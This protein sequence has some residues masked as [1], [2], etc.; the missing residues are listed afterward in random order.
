MAPQ[1]NAHAL[2]AD[3]SSDGDSKV[4]TYSLTSLPQYHST[5]NKTA[6]LASLR[7]S[8]GKL[9]DEVNAF[10]TKKMEQEKTTLGGKEKDLRKEEENYGE[11]DVDA[12]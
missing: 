6:Y 7:A 12:A 10:L 11:E 5:E 3:Y 4:F 1:D 9:Q 8:V 2:S